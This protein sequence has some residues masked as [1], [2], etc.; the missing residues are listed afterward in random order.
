MQ[1]KGGRGGQLRFNL[2]SSLFLCAETNVMHGWYW[3]SAILFFVIEYLYN[4]LVRKYSLIYIIFVQ[5][6]FLMQ[7]LMYIEDP[8]YINIYTYLH[9]SCAVFTAV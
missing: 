7:T 8:L 3:K 9:V 5:S 2:D 1:F 6:H 4:I